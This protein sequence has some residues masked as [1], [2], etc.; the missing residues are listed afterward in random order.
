V[1]RPNESNIVHH[2]GDELVIDKRPKD[3]ASKRTNMRM[4]LAIHMSIRLVDPGYEPGLQ[5]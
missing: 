5:R 4:T 1:K 2:D 3:K